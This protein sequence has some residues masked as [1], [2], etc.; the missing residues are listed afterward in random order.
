[1]YLYLCLHVIFVVILHVITFFS[2]DD[3]LLNN[4]DKE[5]VLRDIFQE[6]MKKAKEELNDLLADFR[7][8]RT[9][10]M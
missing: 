5:E 4:I 7:N 8:K 2:L 3:V 1:M 9:M 10:G 6:A